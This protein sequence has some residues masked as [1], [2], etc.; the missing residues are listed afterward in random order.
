VS[1]IS[2]SFIDE[3]FDAELE[4]LFD[5]IHAMTTWRLPFQYHPSREAEIRAKL[6]RGRNAQ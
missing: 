1:P 3:D 5:E 4:R 2:L 6:E